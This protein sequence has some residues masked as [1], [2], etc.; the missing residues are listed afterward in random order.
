[1][2][3]DFLDAIHSNSLLQA[4]SIIVALC[5]AVYYFGKILLFVGRNSWRR[6]SPPL[7]AW[8]DKQAQ[9]QVS[10][11][12]LAM[13]D[14]V[15]LIAEVS[16]RCLLALTF[17]V[18]Y[19]AILIVGV[20]DEGVRNAPAL[21]RIAPQVLLLTSAFRTGSLVGWLTRIVK[22]KIRELTEGDSK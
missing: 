12:R 20:A 5:T 13:V 11:N 6:L 3:I 4:I 1:M 9:E 19:F 7:G 15:F 8:M 2:G 18:M 14:P 16:R 17:L 22:E 10:K 21:V